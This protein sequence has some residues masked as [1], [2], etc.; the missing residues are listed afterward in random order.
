[1]AKNRK[2][3]ENFDFSGEELV[4]T[5]IQ[6]PKSMHLKLKYYAL[7]NGDLAL[8]AAAQDILIRHL[9][10]YESPGSMAALTITPKPHRVASRKPEN[11]N[12]PR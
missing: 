4:R 1:M 10:N 7:D 6:L 12:P 8:A 9:Q 3:T 2:S 5:N 11:H